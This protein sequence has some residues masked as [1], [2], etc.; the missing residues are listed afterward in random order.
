MS[1]FPTLFQPLSNSFP[2]PFERLTDITNL[3]AA[4]RK[5]EKSSGWKS[6]VQRIT[7]EP[8]R[9]CTAL[10]KSLIDGAYRPGKGFKFIVSE[11]G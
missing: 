5:L 11:R 10:R 1:A 3:L 8:L 9:F 4:V 7:C 6:S 2:T